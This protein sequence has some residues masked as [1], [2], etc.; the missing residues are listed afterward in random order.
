MA[1]MV[2]TGRGGGQGLGEEC[3]GARNAGAASIPS[4]STRPATLTEGKPQVVELL[5]AAA[6]ADD[7]L[8][9][10]ASL[11]AIERASTAA[12]VLAEARRRGIAP[13]AVHDSRPA[14]APA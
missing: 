13:T 8:R 11:G 2:A 10:A 1:I 5:P 6:P 4:S 3:R 12:A 14:R 7:I 9:L